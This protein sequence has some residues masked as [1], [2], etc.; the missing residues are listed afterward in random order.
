MQNHFGPGR[1]ARSA[2]HSRR[3]QCRTSDHL[4]RRLEPPADAEESDLRVAE[5]SVLFGRLLADV[6]LIGSPAQIATFEARLARALQRET[7][8]LLADGPRR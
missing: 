7:A 6:R 2:R 1:H 4:E 3:H 5:T 8:R